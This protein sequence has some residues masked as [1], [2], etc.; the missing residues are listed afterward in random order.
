MASSDPLIGTQLGD[1]KIERLLGTGGM[2]RVYLGYDEKLERHPPV[3]VTEPTLKAAGEFEDEFR[4]RF[5]REARAIARLKHP[6]SVGVYQFNQVGSLY[7]M[8]MELVSGRD[9]RQILR[10]HAQEGTLLP[11]DQLLTVME[12]I[13]SALDYAHQQGV[14]HRDVKPSNI[15][16]KEDGH[17][18]LMDFGLVLRAQEGTL[19]NTFGSVHYIA[20]EQAMSSA[21][22]VAQS[23]LY[24]LGWCSEMLSGRVVR[25]R[26][27]R[28]WRS[29]TS[30]ILHHRQQKPQHQPDVEQVMMRRST[31]NPMAFRLRGG[32]L[33]ALDGLRAGTGRTTAVG[34]T[35]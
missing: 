1:Y 34:A 21:K 11:R 24:S 9:L 3:K 20:P 26:L 15:M 8:A 22:A 33:C 16:I 27:G 7:Y 5:V 31:K 17:A 12:D 13:S 23:D 6:H 32:F 18:V 30:A 10:D 4:R 25:R 2:A 35:A 19:G 28:A 29:G 14:I